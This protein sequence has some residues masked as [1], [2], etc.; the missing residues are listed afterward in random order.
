M[1]RS[2][3][4]YIGNKGASKASKQLRAGTTKAMRQ[5]ASVDMN[6]AKKNSR[7]KKK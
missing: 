3:Q 2:S 4:N 7:A 6:M 5:V 1:A